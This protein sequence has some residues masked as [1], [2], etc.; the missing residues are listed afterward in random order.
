MLKTHYLD[1]WDHFL[2]FLSLHKNSDY[3]VNKK[4]IEQISLFSSFKRAA[5]VGQGFQAQV[6]LNNSPGVLNVDNR[7]EKSNNLVYT[8]AIL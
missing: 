6:Y 8:I 1:E 7:V 5:K 4:T 2:D 3:K